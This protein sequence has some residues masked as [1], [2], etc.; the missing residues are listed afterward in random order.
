[1]STF[2]TA[3]ARL[4]ETRLPDGRTL[5]W[6]EWGP[7]DGL[8]VLLCPGAATSRRLGFGPEAVAALGVRLVSTDRPGLGAS[9]PAPGRTF[10]DFAEDMRRLSERRGL[11]RPAVVGNSQGAPFALACAVEGVASALAVVSGADEVA[12]PEFADALTPEL[13][14]VVA[15]TAR[16][17]GEAEAFFAGLGPDAMWRMVMA[18][19][20]ESD[21][22]VYRQPA[23]A[24]AYRAA[25]DE[26]FVQGGAGYAR[27]TVLAMGRW[28]FALDRITVPVDIWYGAQ[29]TG[30]S[31]DNGARLA[32]RVP[33]ARRHLVPGVGG[34]VL[35][36]RAEE[37]LATL[38]GRG[39][40]S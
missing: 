33:G 20:P 21:L 10:A 6:A 36:T 29:D 7:E 5:G 25:L 8:P 2:T 18:G 39:G 3:P 12:A 22:A 28:P 23:F 31:P 19:S 13:R 27:D 1:M 30:H 16:D 9:S 14:G 34:A 11:G 15:R 32:A 17:P 26:A 40:D 35:W 24:A 37:I 38:V 4:G